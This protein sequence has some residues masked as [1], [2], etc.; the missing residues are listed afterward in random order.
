MLQKLGVVHGAMMVY[1]VRRLLILAEHD[2]CRITDRCT[3]Q[4]IRQDFGSADDG[5]CGVIVLW[6]QRRGEI[7]RVDAGIPASGRQDK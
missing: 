6:L 5:I 1:Y 2:V 3:V 4:A 7:D